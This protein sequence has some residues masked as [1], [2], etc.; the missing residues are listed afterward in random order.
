MRN[1]RSLLSYVSPHTGC[2]LVGGLLMAAVGL[3]EGATA[4]L[5][6]PLMQVVLQ[7]GGASQ[8]IVLLDIPAFGRTY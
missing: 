4:L 1:M 7:L 3:L 8:Q 2:L 5:F 6:W